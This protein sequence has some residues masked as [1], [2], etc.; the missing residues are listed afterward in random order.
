MCFSRGRRRPV[1]IA[2]IC[3]ARL[4]PSTLC[5]ICPDTAAAFQHADA[6]T[7]SKA[8]RGQQ[9]GCCSHPTQHHTAGSLVLILQVTEGQRGAQEGPH[10]APSLA[11]RLAQS[12]SP[13]LQPHS[14]ETRS[15]LGIL[16]ARSQHPLR[17]TSVSENNQGGS[18]PAEG[19]A[20]RTAPSQ[21]HR[22]GG[23][24]ALPSAAS[25]RFGTPS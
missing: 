22:R 2:A 21:C 4:G 1:A 20:R 8:G 24:R 10:C 14:P 7:S 15:L 9:R 3:R 5:P 6:Q 25:T 11:A 12:P 23:Q 18:S 17:S 13:S 16:T 19:R